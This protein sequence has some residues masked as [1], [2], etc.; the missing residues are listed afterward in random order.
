M[1]KRLHESVA[2]YLNTLE[3]SVKEKLLQIRAC[4]FELIPDDEEGISYQMPAYKY[5][6]LVL[7]MAAFK[8]H[9][10]LYPTAAPIAH[11][12]AQLS[13]YKTSKGA[14]QFPLD[15]DLP[16]ALIKEIILFNLNRKQKK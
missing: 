6:G 2:A 3:P 13:A 5:K 15:H 7:C 4:V 10:G 14:I 1:A 9:I 16:M 11:F 8:N 12:A